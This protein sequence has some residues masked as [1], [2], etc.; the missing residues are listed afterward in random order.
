MET[1][2]LFHFQIVESGKS[3]FPEAFAFPSIE[4]A[5]PRQTECPFSAADRKLWQSRSPLIRC[6]DRQSFYSDL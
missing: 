3:E 2:K 6:S 4:K 1:S 5:G